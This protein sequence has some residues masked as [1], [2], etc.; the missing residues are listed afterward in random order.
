MYCMSN[1]RSINF[2]EK[3][4][5][6]LLMMSA[7][8][9]CMNVASTGAQAVYNRQS[10]K[11]TLNDQLITRD[12]YL[13]L[14]HKTHEFKNANISIATFNQEVLLAGEVPE[15]WQKQKIQTIIKSLPDIKRVYNLIEIASPSS[16]LTRLNDVWI[17]AK[18]KGQFIAS[19]DLDVT[20]IKVVTENSTVY[21][22]GILPADAARAAVDIA[23]NTEGVTKVVKIFSYIHINKEISS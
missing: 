15:A 5:I 23:S 4:V 22:M 20:Q 3:L 21:L 2:W 10:I 16:T 1:M 12:V 8:Q 17:T 6:V 18:I 11:K 7:L 14:Q 13:A 19:E 9:G